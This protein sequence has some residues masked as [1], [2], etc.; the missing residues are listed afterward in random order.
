MPLMCRPEQQV[1]LRKLI[2]WVY[3]S[4]EGKMKLLKAYQ[5]RVICGKLQKLGKWKFK[6]KQ[7][8]P[9]LLKNVNVKNYSIAILYKK[10]FY[11]T[12]IIFTFKLILIV[13]KNYY[14]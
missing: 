6:L 1:Y 12:E 4:I 2:T 5:T 13:E 9:S 7:T 10:L 3:Y 8:K 11:S 14:K